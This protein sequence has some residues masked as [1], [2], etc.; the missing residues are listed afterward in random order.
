MEA[1]AQPAEL[2]C[3][4]CSRTFA[5]GPSRC[6]DDGASLVRVASLVTDPMIGRN[7]EGRFTIQDRLGFG[8]MGAVYRAWQHSVERQVAVK[9]IHV[10][11]GRDGAAAK[12]FLREVKLT[13]RI[14]HPNTVTVLDFGQC[15]D[16]MLYL[17]MELLEGRTLDRVLAAEGRFSVDRLVRVGVQLCEA[18]EAAHAASIIHRDLKPSNIMVLDGPPGRDA[19]KV[20][21]FGLAKSLGEEAITR[22]GTVI[23]TPIYL[24]PEVALGREADAR[25]DLYSLGV[26]LYQLVSGRPPFDGG[27]VRDV[28]LHHIIAQPAPLP[29]EVPKAVSDVLMRLLAKKP[30]AR[31]G[32]APELREA[33][34]ALSA[35]EGRS[36]TPPVVRAVA[37]AGEVAALAY[38]STDPDP[39]PAPGPAASQMVTTV[40]GVDL[41]VARFTRAPRQMAALI[42]A[43]AF[44]LA[45]L[46]WLLL[47][48]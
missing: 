40:T 36:L 6:P 17:A 28:M 4:R 32:S 7:L 46:A 33:L 20:L 47:R 26:I 11:R 35:T 9:V 12:R 18:L 43:G 27:K 22:A 48:G 25:S 45:L 24:S 14:S 38:R 8:G 23:G 29:R 37:T 34:L 39:T 30:A 42:A 21:D 5:A 10:G 44:A 31:Y 1:L 2:S 15:A 19:L 16:G 13:S 41:I 3:P